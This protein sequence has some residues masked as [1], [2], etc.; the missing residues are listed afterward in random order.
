[1]SLKKLLCFIALIFS[2]GVSNVSANIIGE[3]LY[4]DIGALIDDSPIESYNINDY[5][6]VVAEDLVKYGFD[7]VWNGELRTL[8]IYHDVHKGY[9]VA[10]DKD[11]IN[12]KKAD[13]PQRKHYAYVYQTDIK[14][15]LDGKEI[16]ACNIDGRTLIQIDHLAQYGEFYYNNDRRMVELRIMKPSFEY[17]LKIADNKV[18]TVVGFYPGKYR[19]YVNYTGLVDD[20]G[21]PDGIGRVYD[22]EMSSTTYAYWDNDTKR[23]CYYEE[24]IDKNGS[25]S[26]M[27]AY[28][29]V[30]MQRDFCIT[31]SGNGY[32]PYTMKGT[33]RYEIDNSCSR[34]GEYDDSY[35]YGFYIANETFY[36]KDGMAINYTNGHEVNFTGV[37]ADK[38]FAQ[39]AYVKADNGYIYAAGYSGATEDTGWPST[40][41]SYKVFTKAGVSQFPKPPVSPSSDNYIQY[42]SADAGAY[43]RIISLNKDGN[44]Y[45]ERPEGTWAELCRDQSDKLDL[46]APVK[47]FEKAKHVNLQ[48]EDVGVTTGYAYIPYF[49]VVDENNNLW[50]WNYEYYG[51]NQIGN[52]YDENNGYIAYGRVDYIKEPIK[53]AQN[54]SKAFGTEEKYLLKTNGAVVR[55]TKEGE[56]QI[57]DNVKDMDSDI[58]GLNFIAIKSDGTV[59]TWGKNQN[60]QC[61]VGH[62]DYVWKPTQIKLVYEILQ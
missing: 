56:E 51:Q 21:K 32:D 42:S 27:Y 23:D 15:F 10:L 39:I 50:H 24:R 3:V 5:T 46:S 53:V 41:Q 11:K 36:D 31:V 20:L 34:D 14:T 30:G 29:S 26:R 1:M 49:Y 22:S 2:I 7:V 13:I 54:V 55:L 6:Y 60:G 37:M 40:G 45:F 62:T 35:L 59:W 18:S 25:I 47:V 48:V 9:E 17:G 28:Q 52:A 61:G 8:S 12:I 43:N 44:V 33:H 19:R 4:T 58:Y 38:R 57:L 16:D